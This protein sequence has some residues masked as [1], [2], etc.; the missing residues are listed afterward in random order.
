MSQPIVRK[1][2]Y[3]GACVTLLGGCGFLD[4][5]G[6]GT[7]RNASAPPMNIVQTA[8]ATW[9][10]PTG[11]AP[12]VSQVGMNSPSSSDRLSSLEAQ[13]MQMQAQMNSLAAGQEQI[14]AVLAE[15]KPAAGLA[16]SPLAVVKETP[17]PVAKAAPVAASAAV[18]ATTAM[19]VRLAPSG[20]PE[21][22]EAVVSNASAMQAR[23]ATSVS[24]A[25]EAAWMPPSAVPASSAASSPVAAVPVVVAPALAAPVP[26]AAPSSAPAA[27]ST[28]T[29]K[30]L[31]VGEHPDKTRLVLDLS[32]NVAFRQDLDNNEH[33]LM[34]E[35][36]GAGW[37]GPL[38]QQFA[39]SPLVSAYQATPDGQGGTHLAVQLRKPAK[40][41]STQSLAAEPGKPPRIVID[42]APL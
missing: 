31:R 14:R 2:L 30:G 5:L 10:E 6:G 18:A 28:A 37:S 11:D 15:M 38:Q 20:R 39:R 41:A 22:D 7:S 24:P 21:A 32:N 40:V 27:A 8:D 23:P 34:I 3:T 13:V 16:V 19:P 4:G 33:I 26:P 12:V 25:P 17:V 42:I 1:I 29:V 35:L 36:P 9:L